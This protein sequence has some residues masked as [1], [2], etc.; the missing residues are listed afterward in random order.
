MKI[1]KSIQSPKSKTRSLKSLTLNLKSSILF[2]L[3]S[4]FLLLVSSSAYAAFSKGDAGTSAVQFLK[5]GAGARSSGMGDIGVGVSEG[6]SSVYWNAAGLAG[7]DKPSISVMHAIWFEDIGY[8]WVGYGQPISE[9]G[10][11]GIGVQYINY[12]SIQGSDTDG[13]VGSNF[14][15]AD[16]SATLSYGNKVSDDVSLGIGVKYI[17]SKIKETGVAIA[18]DVGMLYKPTESGMSIGIALQN[19]GSKMK[20]VAKDENL[21]MTIRVGG[22][23]NIQPEWLVGLDITAVNDSGIGIGAGTEYKHDAGEG[24]TLI[25]RAG[26]NTKTKDIGGLKGISLGAGLDYKGYGLDYAFVPFGDLGDTHRVS[27]NM[28]F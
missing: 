11:I 13:I 24:T 8:S 26:Y 2:F 21:P 10:V 28:K 3:T 14:N 19:V 9:I 12:G 1:K 23:Y 7:I 15:P 17:S 4:C 22:G 5:M 6:A 18:G 27:L 20:Y 16:M 25:G